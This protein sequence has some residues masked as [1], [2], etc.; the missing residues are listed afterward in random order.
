MC[1]QQ[2]IS[3]PTDH[4]HHVRPWA[5]AETTQEKWELLLDPNNLMA[6]CVEHHLQVHNEM[7]AKKKKENEKQSLYYI[8]GK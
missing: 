1:L 8:S 4:I 3:T 7:R 6:L 2:G 5:H